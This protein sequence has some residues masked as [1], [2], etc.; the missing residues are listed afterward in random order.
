[1]ALS[2]WAVCFHIPG[3]KWKPQ[4]R[5]PS[6]EVLGPSQSAGIFLKTSYPAAKFGQFNIYRGQQLMGLVG[7]V[8]KQQHAKKGQSELLFIYFW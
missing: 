7:E 3:E 4:H 2:S 1:M 8:N 5:R 6:G